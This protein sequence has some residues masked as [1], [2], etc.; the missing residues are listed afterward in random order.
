MT[1]FHVASV[2]LSL[3]VVLYSDE[4]GLLWFLGKKKTLSAKRIQILHVLVSI[5]LG[6]IL[7]TGGLMFLDRSDYLLQEPIFIVKMLFVLA[8]VVNA[9][10]IE[11]ISKLA[12]QKAFV[13]LTTTERRRVLISGAVSVI[14]W[15][16]AGVCGLLLG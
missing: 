5:G 10:F 7:L 9:F 15:I 3:L 14:G 11:S 8:L 12:T 2:I 4:Q 16:G 6:G 13:E 1:E